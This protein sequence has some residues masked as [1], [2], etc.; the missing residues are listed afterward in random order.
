MAKNAIYIDLSENCVAGECE[1]RDWSA[2]VDSIY[3]PTDKGL[4]LEAYVFPAAKRGQVEA[5]M[6]ELKQ[7]KERHSQEIHQ[8]HRLLIGLH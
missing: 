6:L 4:M 1:V 8:I 2:V 3:L 7:A 5:I